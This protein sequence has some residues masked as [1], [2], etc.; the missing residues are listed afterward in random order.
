VREFFHALEAQKRPAQHEQRRHGPGGEGAHEQ[1]RGHEDGL[2]HER[3]LGHGPD[4]GQ[5]AVGAHAG[6]LLGVERQIVA[7]HARRLLRRHLGEHRHVVGHGGA[8]LRG[9]LGHEGD[10]VEDGRDVV[11]QGEQAA[12]GHGGVL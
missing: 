5:L 12:E 1:G 6:D 8:F 4:H 10:V 7:E 3:A 9:H 2:V 11:E